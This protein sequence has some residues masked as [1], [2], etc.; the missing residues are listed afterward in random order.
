MN[1]IVRAVVAKITT[2][3]DRLD[4]ELAQGH[5]QPARDTL[6]KLRSTLTE[7]LKWIK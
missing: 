1:F 7:V 5:V 4:A 2:L 3:M 6:Q